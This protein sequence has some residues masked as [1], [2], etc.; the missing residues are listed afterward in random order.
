MIPVSAL[1][2]GRAVVIKSCFVTRSSVGFLHT[3][4]VTRSGTISSSSTST[5]NRSATRRWASIE[6]EVDPGVVEGT[7]L[8]VLKYPH[9]ALRAP[10]V[11][12]TEE[13]LKDGTIAKIAKEMLLVM[14]A[15]VGM[16]LAAPQVG[17][18]K[19]LMVFNISGDPKK[20]LLETILVNPKI[21]Q[22]SDSKDI[23]YEGCL[24]FPKMNGPVE[25]SKAITVEALNIKGKKITKKYKGWDARLFQHEYD[26][27][28][29]KV[30][31]D[32]LIDEEKLKVQPRLDELIA[33]FGE[34]GAL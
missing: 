11:D 27:L 24:S 16:G 10:N 14:Y 26:H 18:N 34:G 28:D 2:A 17:I 1:S 3:A 19:R 31:I 8:R 15:S 29:G 9:P 6:E 5:A 23:H 30:Y 7:N 22:Y 33:E 12:V 21:V 13:E 20:W 4:A 32:R 25:R